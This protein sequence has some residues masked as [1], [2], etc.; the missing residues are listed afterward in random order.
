M[1]SGAE[2]ARW[3]EQ[4][5]EDLRWA[6]VLLEQGGYHVV[7]FLAQQV[8]EKSLKAVL[9]HLGEEAVLGHSVER[10]A[11]EVAERFPQARARSARW[12]TL[13]VHYV[14][15]RYPNSVPGSIPARV[16]DRETAEDALR[17]AEE[18][19]SFAEGA[20]RGG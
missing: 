14:A 9:Y 8:A 5:K 2:G 13:D 7:A 3:L 19:V 16:Y 10:L 15:S 6:R 18:V 1:R 12:A 20:L 17:I 4:A 11:A